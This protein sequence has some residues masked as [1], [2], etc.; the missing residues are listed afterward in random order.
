[1]T[2]TSGKWPKTVAA[3]VMSTGR[4]RVSASRIAASF[5]KPR[6]CSVL[7]ELD[8]QDAVLGDQPDQRDQPDLRVDVDRGEVEEA[9]DQRA[10]IARGTE[11]SR[12]SADRG[13]CGTARR[14]R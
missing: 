13:S 7:A 10:Q 14:A 6:A 2:S 1:V 4:S 3:E 8:D 11:P 12:T 5:E 9:E